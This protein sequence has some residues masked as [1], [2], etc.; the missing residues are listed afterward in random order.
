MWRN[1][2]GVVAGIVVWT[3]LV[4]AGGL[5]MR[6]FWPAY[7]AADTPAMAFDLS[8]KI[9]RLTLSTVALIAASLAASR[10]ARSSQYV[11]IALGV[12]LLLAFIPIHYN[13]WSKFPVWYHLFFLTSL[14]VLPPLTIRVGTRPLASTPSPG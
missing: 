6:E 7:A 4:T 9:A 3:V 14:V 10:V 12:V 2:L 11:A 8:M 5:A 1:V 13:L